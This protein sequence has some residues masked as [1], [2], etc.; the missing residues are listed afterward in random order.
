MS[1][2]KSENINEIQEYPFSKL[3]DRVILFA[4]V[5]G[6]L[7]LISVLWILTFSVQSNNLLRTVNSVFINNN[8]DRRI[9]KT[10]AHKSGKAELLGYW[11]SMYN[12][13]DKMFVFGVFN[14]GILVPLGAILSEDG[15]VKEL[16]PLSAH[17]QQVYKNM[18]KSILQMYINRIEENKGSSK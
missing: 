8:D 3:K 12:S 6:L 5:A 4:W 14:D 17:A 18:P 2:N 11:Y 16:L 15:R 1:D 10:I 9:F 13:T 7:I